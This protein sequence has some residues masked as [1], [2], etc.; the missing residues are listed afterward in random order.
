MEEAADHPH[1]LARGAFIEVGGVRQPAPAPRF[2]TTVPA[3]PRPPEAVDAAAVLAAW[4]LDA[5][6]IN[7]LAI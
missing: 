2:G 5:A 6:E 7:S 4:G 3:A 1:N